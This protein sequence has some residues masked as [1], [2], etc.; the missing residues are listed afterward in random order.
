MSFCCKNVRHFG[1]SRA[2]HSLLCVQS[3]PQL[4]LCAALSGHVIMLQECDLW[5][6]TREPVTAT[7]QE[8]PVHSNTIVTTVSAG[9]DSTVADGHHSEWMGEERAFS[10]LKHLKALQPLCSTCPSSCPITKANWIDFFFFLSFTKSPY[11]ALLW[12][13]FSSELL[14]T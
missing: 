14:V 1:L 2:W 8:G 11:I 6:T 7:S 5:C 3:C 10:W 13:I 4:H 12:H 9:L